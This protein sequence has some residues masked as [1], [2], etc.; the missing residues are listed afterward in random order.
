MRPVTPLRSLLPILFL[1][2]PAARAHPA[3][4]QGEVFPATQPD[5]QTVSVRI[6]GDEYYRVV[7]S[8]DGYTL[9]PDPA[10]GEICYARVS[11]DGR[12]LVSTG[13]RAGTDA[14]RLGLEKHLR[15]DPKVRDE[16]ARRTRARLAA[17]DAQ[18]LAKLKSRRTGEVTADSGQVL[19]LTLLI[20]F[21]DVEAT[22]PAA[23]IEAFCNEPGYDA[24]GNNGS[25][26]DYFLDVSDGILD[27]TNH[28]VPQYYR[29]LHEK[30]YYTDFTQPYPVRA[31]ELILEALNALE[32]SGYDL[33]RHDS[34]GDGL[35]DAINAFYA[36]TP[37]SAW[38][39]GLW[40]HSST[41]E[42][43]A[44][45]VASY[46]YQISNL[47]EYLRL[48]V[49]CHE[50]GHMLCL[51]PDL[52]DY[53]Y[54]SRGA[55]EFCLMATGCYASYEN[56]A[57][58][59]AP[60]KHYSGWDDSTVLTESHF[61]FALPAG[62]N[63]FVLVPH[64]TLAT[65]YFMLENR[66]RAGRLAEA[67]ADGLAIWHVDETS[68]NDHQEMLSGSHYEVALLQADGHFSLEL[69][70]NAG[71]EGDLW[72]VDTRW[73]THLECT[74][75][76]VP[77]TDWWSG[78]PS[79]LAVV[80]MSPPGPV[81]VVDVILEAGSNV[82]P[83]AS[84]E[85]V[86]RH[87][88]HPYQARFWDASLAGDTPITGW[89]WDFGDGTTSTERNPV[90]VYAEAGDFRPSL[91]VSNYLGVHRAWDAR[92]EVR[93]D[94]GLLSIASVLQYN[95]LSGTAD[96]PHEGWPVRVAGRVFVEPGTHA[97][98]GFSLMDTTGGILVEAADAPYRLG[99]QVAA[100]GR[101]QSIGGE[102][103]VT[104]AEVACLGPGDPPEPMRLSPEEAMA[105][106]S[107]VGCFVG[108]TG[109]VENLA[110]HSF[111]LVGESD[112]LLV[113]IDPATDID[114]SQVTEGLQCRV[115]GALAS[116]NGLRNLKPRSQGDLYPEKIDEPPA[117][118]GPPGF[119][120][121]APN[122]ANPLT[123]I[124][125]RVRE[126]SRVVLAIHD[127]QGRRVRTL[128]D[129][130]LAPAEYDL[131]WDGLDDHGAPAASAPYLVRLRIG[132]DLTEVRKL[133]LLK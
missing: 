94:P 9:I 13:V 42:F 121:I 86:T 113:R 87:G 59:C 17:E 50:N 51:W 81:M 46:R 80:D 37:Q 22:I 131:P 129:E 11:G 57:E 69:D 45:G 75:N 111:E 122:P 110:D 99:D 30:V 89:L 38:A 3:P 6:W 88:Y 126:R 56:P 52:Y 18:L 14:T 33:S 123:T 76:T 34:N 100:Y 71:D 67:P 7:E 78:E 93:Q 35:I 103:R 36:G 19:G 98:R 54:D 118:T 84:F 116:D 120:R 128:L 44:D 112:R 55:G 62:R 2:L 130:S 127:L 85:T 133:T 12:E 40:P 61:D 125:L 48:G 108:V 60:L 16:I 24:N 29:A 66:H 106:Y 41:I 20:D 10:T 53:D 97:G 4:V 117:L 79:G 39:T 90:H 31:R 64:P 49:F 91:A 47:G 26:R 70:F 8:L 5:G 25:V 43:E 68:S 124:R 107:N 109:R 28:V 77:S 27:Y 119:V 74:P 63:E 21:P 96:S 102:L 101:L 115:F 1:L 95:P 104:R 72:P 114:L 105:D 92:I 32:A 65:E 83:T 82:L 58:P 15:I 132:N 23:E 73:Q